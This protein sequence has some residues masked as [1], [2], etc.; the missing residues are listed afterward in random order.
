M[1]SPNL[2]VQD[3]V[4]RVTLHTPARRGLDGRQ[5]KVEM[6]EQLAGLEV[7]Y[8]MLQGRQAC[9]KIDKRTSPDP[10]CLLLNTGTERNYSNTKTESFNFVHLFSTEKVNYCTFFYLLSIK[11]DLFQCQNEVHPCFLCIPGAHDQ[12]GSF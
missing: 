8:P 6:Q 12:V 10:F 1:L 2:A 4:N 3:G 5:H 7:C 9:S 11:E